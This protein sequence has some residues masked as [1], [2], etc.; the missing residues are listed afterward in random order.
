MPTYASLPSIYAISVTAPLHQPLSIPI[1]S[2]SARKRPSRV[3]HLLV[4]ALH[5]AVALKQMYYVAIVVRQYLHLDVPRVFDISLD[6]ASAIA[7]C[8]LRLTVLCGSSGSGGESGGG[9]GRAGL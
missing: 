5:G 3:P 1:Q 4:A 7:E 8:G 6:E 9:A 2:P